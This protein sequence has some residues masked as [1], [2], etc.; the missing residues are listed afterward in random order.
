MRINIASK[1]ALVLALSSCN[2]EKSKV[3]EAVIKYIGSG[4]NATEKE[5]LQVSY[6][7]T[8]EKEHVDALRQK[9][10]HT[11]N[12][13]HDLSVSKHMLEIETNGAS[14]TPPLETGYLDYYGAKID[15]LN[16]ITDVSGKVIKVNAYVLSSSGDTAYKNTIWLDE[17]YEVKK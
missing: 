9:Y 3:E 4:L 13:L 6:S 10:L 17:K 8:T 15:S 16:A 11:M 1:I 12:S 14:N 7:W 5:N 2:A